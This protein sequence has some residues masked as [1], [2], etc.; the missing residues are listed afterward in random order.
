MRKQGRS[1]FFWAEGIK[2]SG[3]SVI[4]PSPMNVAYEVVTP[5]NVP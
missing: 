5:G 2:F 1:S 3:L 4:V